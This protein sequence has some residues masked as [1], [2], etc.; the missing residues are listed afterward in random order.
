M[1][2]KFYFAGL[3]LL[4][5]FSLSACKSKESAYKKAYDQAR[6]REMQQ[7]QTQPQAPVILDDDSYG[8]KPKV[9]DSSF[10]LEKITAVDNAAGL[11][12]YN[13][14]IGSFANKT[15]A[16]SLKERMIAKG[17]NAIVAQNER[18]MYRVIVASFN[19]KAAASA[20]RDNFKAQFTPDFQ[21]AWLLEQQY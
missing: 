15:N 21:D 7:T 14:V 20:A 18:Q 1:K 13:V 11:Q 10:Q 6:E 3:A 17:Y 16:V 9:I 2:S 5:L 12:R 8:T 4:F 19:N